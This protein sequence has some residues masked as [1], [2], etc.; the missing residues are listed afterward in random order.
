[1]RGGAA[2]AFHARA[3]Q[4]FLSQKVYFRGQ[5]PVIGRIKARVGGAFG[6]SEVP[7]APVTGPRVRPPASQEPP[8][9][10]A[11]L[12]ARDTAGRSDPNTESLNR[13]LFSVLGK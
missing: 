9:G 5:K 6:S 1:M 10:T 12:T 2:A 3:L 11:E 8:A 4:P 13:V 7:P